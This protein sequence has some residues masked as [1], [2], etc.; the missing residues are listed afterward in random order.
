MVRCEAISTQCVSQHDPPSPLLCIHIHIPD[1]VNPP[2]SQPPT[3][4]I[5]SLP[6]CLILH[7]F[8]S[9]LQ[10]TALYFLI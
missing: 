5:Y 6:V 7:H 1:D 2:T 10:R 4:T 3:H 8:C 9:V